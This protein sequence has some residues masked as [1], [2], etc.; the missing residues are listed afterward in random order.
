MSIHFKVMKYAE[1]T[2]KHPVESHKEDEVLM[3]LVVYFV[4]MIVGCVLI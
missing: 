2:A 3:V 1:N 4:S